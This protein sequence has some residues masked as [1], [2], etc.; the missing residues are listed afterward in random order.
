MCFSTFEVWRQ[1]PYTSPLVLRKL[2]SVVPGLK[3][4]VLINEELHNYILH[5]QERGT[6]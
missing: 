5:K 4:D 3:T 6:A 2:L 1:F